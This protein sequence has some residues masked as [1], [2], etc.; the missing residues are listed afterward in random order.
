MKAARTIAG[1]LCV[2]LLGL[3]GA[4]AQSFQLSASVSGSTVSLNWT[5]VPG[6]SLYAL[7]VQVAGGP[8][9]P[10]SPVGA[11]TSAQFFNVPAATYYVRAWALAGGQSVSSNIATVVVTVPGTAPPAPT[12]LTA[13]VEGNSL[14]LSWSL[15]TTAGLTAL[16]AE[17]LTGPGGGVANQIPIRVSTST[18]VP[19]VPNGVHTVRLRGVGGSGF[20]APSNEVTFA[21]PGGCTAPTAPTVTSSVNGSSVTVNWTASALA[22]G[23]RLDVSAA[24]GG[25][26]AFSQAFGGSVTSLSAAGVAPGT[27]FVRVTAFNACGAS[28]TGADAQVSVTSTQSPAVNWTSSQWRAWFFDMLQRRGI[29]NA[30]T[31]ANMQA[32]RGEL[33]ALGADWQNGWRGDF[34]PRIFVPIPGCNQTQPNQPLVCYDKYIDVGDAG[35]NNASGCGGPWAWHPNFP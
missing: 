6:A 2:V 15:P 7:E 1:V 34:R 4:E 14:V 10:P 27:Y 35:C 3:T 13:Q 11:L 9:V 32:T 26:A 28:A 21:V 25:P 19:S 18:V 23:Y 33:N 29:S 17:V 5:A 24:A 31:F 8:H 20:S 22:T 16:V 30:V 12:N